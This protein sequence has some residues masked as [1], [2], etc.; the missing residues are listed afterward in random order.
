LI[1]KGV[2]SRRLSA[3]GY[4]EDKPLDKGTSDAIRKKNRRVEFVVE[5]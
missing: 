4:G 2:D 3:E 5:D 1:N